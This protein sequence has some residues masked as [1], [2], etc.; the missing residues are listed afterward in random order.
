VP[1]H[2][3]SIAL[4]AAGNFRPDAPVN[5]RLCSLHGIRLPPPEEADRELSV[6]H[7]PGREVTGSGASVNQVVRV[8]WSPN[9]LGSNLR[10]VLTALMTSGHVFTIGEEVDAGAAAGSGRGSRNTKLFKILWGLG[11]RLPLPAEDQ[12]GS[13]RTM[14]ERITSF[15]WAKE[16]SQGRALLAYATD[17]DDVVIMSVQRTNSGERSSSSSGTQPVW[18]IREEARFDS[19]G[20]HQVRSYLA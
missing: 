15:S 9:G 13:Y 19:R 16:I 7:I 20:P 11:A 10:P 17:E 6:S 4:Q 8:E 18:Q 1:Q 5:N 3:F 2:Q 14:D 12:E